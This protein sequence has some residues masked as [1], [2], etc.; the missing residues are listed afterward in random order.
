[1]RKDA[2]VEEVR[3][4]R[5]E[6]ERECQRNPDKL[7]EHFQTSQRKLGNRLVCRSPN[8]LRALSQMEKVG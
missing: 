6:I 5:H 1:M 7:F 2:I 8:P 4:I 3:R